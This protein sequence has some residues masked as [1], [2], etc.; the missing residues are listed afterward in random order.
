V[1]LASTHR[2][3]LDRTRPA[4]ERTEPARAASPDV[5]HLSPADRLKRGIVLVAQGRNNFPIM[6]VRE[7]L[8][9][10]AY[11]R[12]DRA[13]Q[14]DINAMYELFPVLYDKRRAPAG[15]LSGGE[16]QILEMAMG[17]ILSPRL[18]LLDEPSLGLSAAMQESVFAAIL[19]L[20]NLGTAVLMV[21]QNAVEALHIADEAVVLELGRISVAGSG[22]AMLQDPEVRRAY[23]GLLA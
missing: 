8:E 17:L 19:R 15:A 20:R 23:L 11:V 12:T 16:Q 2:R 21:E 3:I 10:G 14:R 6:S 5:T 9:M 7:N 1:T 13:V 22:V 18:V 4:G